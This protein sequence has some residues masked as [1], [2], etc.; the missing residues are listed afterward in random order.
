MNSDRLHG[1][2]A[3]GAREVAAELL[4]T[5]AQAARRLTAG[6]RDA[7]HDFRVAVRRLHSWLQ[8]WSP[9]LHPGRRN[10]RRMR[11]LAR[12]TDAARDA[13]VA[14]DWID[15]QRKGL[16]PD[17][18]V[19]ARRLARRVEARRTRG[20]RRARR[21][22][23]DR[24]P[25]LERRLRRRLARSTEP[26]GVEFGHAA[27]TLVLAQAERLE[28][29]LESLHGP[30][31]G[32]RE[33]RARLRAKRLRYLLEP[34]GAQTPAMPVAA[35][36]GRALA[37]LKALQDLLG[38]LQDLRVLAARLRAAARRA[39]GAGGRGRVD[40][41]LHG[42]PD[43]YPGAATDADSLPGL[44]ALARTVG[45]RRA[46]CR[47]GLHRRCADGGAVATARGVGVA[48]AP[49]DEEPVRRGIARAR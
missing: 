6:E 4:D 36:V 34:L 20:L 22:V 49:K 10:L 3:A 40:A 39:G 5:A 7:V 16:A 8:A 19:G 26:A 37:D 30:R 48:L 41:A 27:G 25:R 35:G 2:A 23:A 9:P 12:A 42:A 46:R 38:E 21:R 29:A 43:A 44:L 18:R 32:R 11:R 13:E 17:E 31:R 47:D 15:R 24:W 1:D 28:R 33:H 14:L 45:V